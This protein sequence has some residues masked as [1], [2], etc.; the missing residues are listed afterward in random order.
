VRSRPNGETQKVYGAKRVAQLTRSAAEESY[1]IFLALEGFSIVVAL[2]LI[3]CSQGLKQRRPTAPQDLRKI[4]YLAMVYSI[5]RIGVLLMFM[6]KLVSGYTIISNAPTAFVS[7][8]K[9]SD[10]IGTAQATAIAFTVPLAVFSLVLVV[11]YGRVA[12][13]LARVSDQ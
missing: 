7:V 4:L 3:V 2:L 12:H 13:Q 9:A 6:S 5:V 10:L 1:G 8:E 11:Y